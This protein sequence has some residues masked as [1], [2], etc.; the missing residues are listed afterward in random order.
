MA[1][2]SMSSRASVAF[3]GLE[4]ALDRPLS[5]L[6]R[7]ET[8]PR[9]ILRRYAKTWLVMA[10]GQPLGLGAGSEDLVIVLSDWS[11]VMFSSGGAAFKAFGRA[12][13]H[14]FSSAFHIFSMVFHQ[15]SPVFI[16]VSAGFHDPRPRL[17]AWPC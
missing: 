5:R 16:D 15:F 8:D 6:R 17:E 3:G 9:I 4:K 14:R 13:F 10:P 7:G 12:V 11:E 2:W 1:P